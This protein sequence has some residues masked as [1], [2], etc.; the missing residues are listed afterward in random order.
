[1]LSS[2]EERGMENKKSQTYNTFILGDNK[3]GIWGTEEMDHL[4]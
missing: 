2:K 3:D 4:R 1:M